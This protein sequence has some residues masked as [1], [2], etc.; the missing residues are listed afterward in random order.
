MTLALFMP[1]VVA[2]LILCV[3]YWALHKIASAFGLPAQIVVVL[4]V[5]LV[6]IGV[7]YLLRLL[8][9]VLP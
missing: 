7:V 9:V 4:D 6:V 5:A 1:V 8:G 2:V 3:V